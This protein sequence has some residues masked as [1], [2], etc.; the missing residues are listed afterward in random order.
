MAC[1]AGAE[2]GGRFPPSRA[3]G[4]LRR[5]AGR[6][7]S[8]SSSSSP[9]RDAG[10]EI[11]ALWGNHDLFMRKVLGDPACTMTSWISGGA[12]A[13]DTTLAELG[14]TARGPSAVQSFPACSSVLPSSCRSMCPWL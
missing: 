12:T 8:A 1:G 14:I 13:R 6:T 9:A 4:G 3:D 10:I 2:G 11:T 7:A 5:T